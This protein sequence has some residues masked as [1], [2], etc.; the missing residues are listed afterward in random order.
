MEERQ[1]NDIYR[2]IGER[3]KN[4]RLELVDVKESTARIV[5]LESNKAKKKN[6]GLVYAECRKVKDSD[7]WCKPYD[8]EIIV[9]KPNV[10]YFDEKQLEI[11]LFHELLHIDIWENNKGEE[12]FRIKSH[13]V[14]EFNC[15]IKEFGMDWDKPQKELELE[16]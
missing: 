5:Y 2:E 9:Y 13:D 10:I 4:S 7:K 16:D 1:K 8:Y 6:G 12:V 3:V 14:E 11:L 15:I